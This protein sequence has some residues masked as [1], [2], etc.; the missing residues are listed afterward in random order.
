MNKAELVLAVQK[1]LGTE[2]SRSEAERALNAVLTSLQ[3]GLKRD[4]TV[5]IV[6]FGAF[7]VKTRPARTG[8]NPQTGAEIRINSSRTV[9]FRAGKDLKR[10]L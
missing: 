9:S 3:R 2:T 7:N 8:R 4:K 1:S 5:Q 6:G 10:A